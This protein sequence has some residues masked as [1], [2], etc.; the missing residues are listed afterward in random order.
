MRV[1]YETQDYIQGC[2]KTCEERKHLQQVAFSTFHN[3][4]TQVCFTCNICMTSLPITEQTKM[5]NNASLKG[6]EETQQGEI[7]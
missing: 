6:F 4:L 3:C 5:K 1:E 7:K 2:I